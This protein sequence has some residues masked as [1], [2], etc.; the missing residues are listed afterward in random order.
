MSHPDDYRDDMERLS[1]QEADEI[2][3]GSRPAA[4]DARVAG[5]AVQRLRTELLAPVPAG[6]ER[7]HLAEMRAAAVNG[8]LTEGPMRKRKTKSLAALGLAATLVLGAGLAAALTLPDQASEV[9]EE[10]IEDLDPPVGPGD[11]GQGQPTVE[12]ANDHGKAVSAV[13][14][15]DSTKGCEHGR[16]VSEAASSKADDKRKNDGDHPGECGPGQGNGAAASA[17]KGNNGNHGQA[18]N[19][20]HGEGNNGGGSTS[21]GSRGQSSDA[22]SNAGDNRKSDLP[23]GVET[24]PGQAKEETTDKTEET[25]DAT[26]QTSETGEVT[27][28]LPA[29]A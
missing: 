11:G 25:T 8:E 20:N 26:E 15:D 27:D 21:A 9:A 5:V 23:H 6:T 24:A 17:A 13:A 28:D 7:R 12:E 1:S 29:G 16:A 4:G 18:N 3:S 19:G 2:L 22:H 14:K 10:R